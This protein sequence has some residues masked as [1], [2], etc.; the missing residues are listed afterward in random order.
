MGLG[1]TWWA[2]GWWGMAFCFNNPSYRSLPEGLVK[3]KVIP[4]RP[5]GCG[6]GGFVRWFFG[7][8]SLRRIVVF[9]QLHIDTLLAQRCPLGCLRQSISLRS[10]PICQRDFWKEDG[11][12]VSLCSAVHNQIHSG[13]HYWLAQHDL[14]VPLA[15]FAL[16]FVQPISASLRF[17]RC[18]RIAGAVQSKA[19][20]FC[21]RKAQVR[22][23]TSTTIS[24][25]GK[26]SI[27]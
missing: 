24:K 21:F 17:S 14:L 11:L 4:G 15:G 22:L 6:Q 18:Q 8:H 5:V 2:V 1:F 12:A 16:H 10:V 20:S 13:F 7:W 9:Q 19:S 23:R 3:H 25:V 26:V 27:Y